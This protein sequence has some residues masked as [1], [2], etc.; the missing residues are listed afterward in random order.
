MRLHAC[1]GAGWLSASAP[2]EK[3]WTATAG[4]AAGKNTVF[5]AA[6]HAGS[7]SGG[8]LQR[9]QT[10]KSISRRGEETNKK[11]ASIGCGFFFASGGHGDVAVGAQ[12]CLQSDDSSVQRRFPAF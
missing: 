12:A 9:V 7:L 8:K 1:S 10:K 5:T 6:V 11:P 3:E 2:S 4:S